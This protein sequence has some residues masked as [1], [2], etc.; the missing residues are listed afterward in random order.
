[1]SITFAA[2]AADLSRLQ[3]AHGAWQDAYGVLSEIAMVGAG[4]I[5]GKFQSLDWAA[6]V[7]VLQAAGSGDANQVR[8]AIDVLA[9]FTHQAVAW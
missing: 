9:G 3:A 4:E 5:P 7:L 1:M 8:S 6:G 2:S